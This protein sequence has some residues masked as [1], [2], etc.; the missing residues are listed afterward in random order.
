[1]L[2]HVRYV[3]RYYI[4]GHKSRDKKQQNNTDKEK[5]I[6]LRLRS[7]TFLYNK[8]YHTYLSGCNLK[9]CTRHV[10]TLALYS[11]TYKKFGIVL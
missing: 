3:K 1:M 4:H 5:D 8:I 10:N 11:R 2:R 6:Y 9:R 7:T